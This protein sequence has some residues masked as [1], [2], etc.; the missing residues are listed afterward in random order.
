MH[1]V[2]ECIAPTELC[3]LRVLGAH[4]GPPEAH[5]DARQ[6]RHRR[7][8]GSVY[9]RGA[10]DSDELHTVQASECMYKCQS[11]AV[12]GIRPVYVDCNLKMQLLS[13]VARTMFVQAPKEG[14]VLESERQS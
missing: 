9:N 2:V 3:L 5:H 13:L 10:G 12:R 1:A 11:P 6:Q 7:E 4:S 8:H 14:R